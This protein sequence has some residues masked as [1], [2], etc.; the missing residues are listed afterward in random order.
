M[1]TAQQLVGHVC[2]DTYQRLLDECLRFQSSDLYLL[3]LEVLAKQSEGPVKDAYEGFLRHLAPQYNST[4]AYFAERS[5]ILLVAAFELFLQ[6]LVFAIVRAHPKK[7]GNV[8]FKLSEILDAAGTED[9]VRQGIEATL[10]KIMYKRP[11]EYLTDIANLLSIDPAPLVAKW[12]I[13]T[14]AKARRDLAVH[15]GWKC[16]S[17][18]LRKIAEAGLAT[19]YAIGDRVFP[20]P[21]G[22]L[23]TVRDTFST[24]AGELM[25]AVISKHKSTLDQ[26]AT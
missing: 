4:R 15:N 5:F 13:F 12:S 23:E 9:L 6:E 20:P 17:T 22:Y 8:E 3:K 16:N 21:E 7:V 11:S 24:L 1:S 2:L 25:G 26:P 19:S 14:E 18:Y 10:N